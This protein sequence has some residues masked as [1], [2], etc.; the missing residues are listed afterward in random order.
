MT[1]QE[2]KQKVYDWFLEKTQSKEIAEAERDAYDDLEL[3]E[4]FC[5]DEWQE[6]GY[7]HIEYHCREQLSYYQN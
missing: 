2:A 6:V 1:A 4:M 3:L 7:E 5:C